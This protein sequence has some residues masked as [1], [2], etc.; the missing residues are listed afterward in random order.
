MLANS[1]KA[2]GLI[3]PIWQRLDVEKDKRG[4]LARLTRIAATD[5][6]AMN[7][8]NRP[9]TEATARRIMDA[10]PGVTMADLGQPQENP[11]TLSA[12]LERSLRS[13]GLTVPQA[14]RDLSARR[15]TKML[16]ERRALYRAIEGKE[17]MRRTAANVRRVPA[18]ER[19]LE[20]EPGFLS[21]VAFIDQDR[22]LE[23]RLRAEVATAA[24]AW[25]QANENLTRLVAELTVRVEALEVGERRGHR[26]G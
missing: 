19:Y 14:A 6:S 9:M 17:T 16:S 11:A 5:L 15:R 13:A 18:W 8:G 1:W 12:R 10:V 26:T 20:V 23:V 22:A 2:K 7:Q 3:Q 25:E 21:D 4:E 24:A